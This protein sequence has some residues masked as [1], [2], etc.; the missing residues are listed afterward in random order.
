M[1]NQHTDEFLSDEDIASIGAPELLE[2]AG[3]TTRPK[4]DDA[5]KALREGPIVTGS[6]WDVKHEPIH[7]T[8]L[9]VDGGNPLIY[10]G[11]SH[12][13]IG[14]PGRGKSM[15]GQWLCLSEARAG[16]TALFLDLEKNLPHF[17]ERLKA[18][19]CTR[20]EAQRIG[21]WRLTKSITAEALERIKA[22]VDANTIGVVVLDSVGRSISRSNIN[23]KNL[24]E[25]NNNDV[26]L[27][28]DLQVD[29]WMRWGCT[30]V[31]I[32]HTVKPSQHSNDSRYAK[33]AGAK[34]DVISGAAYMVK[35]AAPF[36]KEKE[37]MAK[38]YVAKDNNGDRAEGQLAAEMHVTPRDEGTRIEIK[39]TM[40]EQKSGDDWRPTVLMAR[41]SE[42]VEKMAQ[43][44]S[45]R[46][47]REAPVGAK[48]GKGSK[49]HID[50]ALR[51]LRDE[52]YID[53]PQGGKITHVK[54]YHQEDDPKSDRFQGDAAGG[55]ASEGNQWF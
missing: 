28:F 15:I 19:G 50:A 26:R 52:G 36:S 14:E 11:M 8:M 31:L 54:S 3:I 9:E 25:N 2:A 38:I 30:P 17:I 44:L 5:Q 12:V 41:I 43:P 16:R 42:W 51:I 1:T 34:L 46:A 7:P 40:P 47:V 21:Y 32:D 35:F 4:E 18:M 24:D 48:G 10:P 53:W 37:G 23:G 49:T 20:E 33:G 39:L 22:F 55:S 13:F 29:P 45:W 27:W 6:W